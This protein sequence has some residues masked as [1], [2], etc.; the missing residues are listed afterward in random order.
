[1][2][3]NNEI[4]ILLGAGFSTEAG[5]PIR[6]DINFRLK[7]L[8]WN[9]FMIYSETTTRFI[10]KPDPNG[11]WQ[12]VKERKFVEAI[13]SFY[14]SSIS[15]NFDYEEFYDYCY[16]LSNESNDPKFDMFFNNYIKDKGDHPNKANALAIT[17][18]TINYL[19]NDLLNFN[20]DLFDTGIIN[21]YLPFLNLL[22]SL[23]KQF[24]VINIFSLNHDLLLEKLFESEINFEYCDGFEISGSKYYIKKKNEQ[25]RV[26]FFDNKF[27][28][29]VRLFKLHGSIDH[30]IY[31][32]SEPYEMVKIPKHL[33]PSDLHREKNIDGKWTEEN[34][35]TLYE[36]IFLSGTTTKIINYD[37]HPF[38]VSQF[39]R[40]TEALGKSKLLISVGYGLQDAKINE[41]IAAEL[42]NNL[43]ILVVKRSKTPATFFEHLNVFHYG[44]SLGIADLN[45]QGIKDYL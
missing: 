37:K 40:F 39:K 19:V 22:K 45:M 30:Y 4:S 15:D 7:N 32:F 1:M 44:N 2:P 33:Y 26:R 42:S 28:K 9:Q 20:N 21:P 23:E 8:E 16:N 36:P 29:Q 13:I 35:W 11:H 17:I 31:N 5:I 41:F 6:S 43:K 18:R 10:T 34:C 3:E 25:I 14:N 24:D 12:N 27:D 38:Y